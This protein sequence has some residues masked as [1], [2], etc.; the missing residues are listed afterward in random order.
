LS[1]EGGADFSQLVHS[2]RGRL[3]VIHAQLTQDI[4]ENK[5]R[6]DYMYTLKKNKIK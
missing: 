1:E 2:G 5:T 6:G 4:P 3:S